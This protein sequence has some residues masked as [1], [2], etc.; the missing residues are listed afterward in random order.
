MPIVNPTP[1]SYSV[2]DI[3]GKRLQTDARIVLSQSVVAG[4]SDT[5]ATG[6]VCVDYKENAI[7]LYDNWMLLIV[8]LLGTVFGVLLMRK[9]EQ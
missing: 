4:A 2:E 5:N 6:E 7:P 3:Q 1:I 9:E 8:I